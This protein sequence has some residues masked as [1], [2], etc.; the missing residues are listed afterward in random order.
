MIHPHSS[1]KR[2]WSS[3]TD[4]SDPFPSPLRKLHN[5]WQTGQPS[6]SSW[7][8]A[9]IRLVLQIKLGI[10]ASLGSK[11]FSFLIKS[12]L[13]LSNTSWPILWHP[14]H[15]HIIPF[16]RWLASLVSNLSGG[17][18]NTPEKTRPHPENLRFFLSLL[19]ISFWLDTVLGSV[20][21]FHTNPPLHWDQPKV[22]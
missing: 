16:R 3:P 2:R 11:P 9:I 8:I 17:L 4:G 21:T 6:L 13:P 20:T 12:S 22:S 7:E 15:F 10:L 14:I 1:G 18:L 19:L 5:Q